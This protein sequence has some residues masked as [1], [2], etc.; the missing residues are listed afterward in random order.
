MPLAL[1]TVVLWPV[2]TM[3][4]AVVN[5]TMYE[6]LA[7][8]PLPWLALLLAVGGVV[9]LLIGLR[10]SR[11]LMPFLGSSAFLVGL[12]AATAAL[13]FPVMLRST[14]NDALS[15]TAYNSAS[16]AASLRQA[17]GWW[18][19]ALPLAVSYLVWVFRVHRGK[20]SVESSGH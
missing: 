17:L 11:P 1:T 12:L 18:L 19:V 5:R 2:L 10:R 6:G 8:R 3:A 9:A 7:S 20:V 13:V 4:T 14:T 15:L 16:A